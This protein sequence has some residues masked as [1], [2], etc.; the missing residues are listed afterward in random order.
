MFVNHGAKKLAPP[1]T[2]LHV[3]CID[4]DATSR[5]LKYFRAL[6]LVEGGKCEALSSRSYVFYDHVTKRRPAETMNF[7]LIDDD[8]PRASMTTPQHSQWSL[9]IT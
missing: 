2:F 9:D 5:K 7:F 1:R 8:H 4:R 6:P 3:E